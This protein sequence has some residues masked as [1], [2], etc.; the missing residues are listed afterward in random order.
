M[1]RL[2]RMR[3]GMAAAVCAAMALVPSVA[4]ASPSAQLVYVRDAT[5]V[6]CPDETALRA[7]VKRRVGYDPFFPWAKTT[8]IVEVGGTG[9]EYV[10]HVRLVDQTGVSRGDRELRSGPKGCSGLVD[11]AA[12]A[13]SIALDMNALAEPV[14]SPEP[15]PEAT[16]APAD[17]PA[18]PPAPAPLAPAPAPEADA[19][20]RP[21]PVA[22]QGLVGL[23]GV[24][25]IGTSPA[26]PSLLPGLDL[27]GAVRRGRGSL[28]LDVRADWPSTT[29]QGEARAAVVLVASSLAPCLHLGPAFGCAVGSLGWI[30]V[31]GERVE[32][33]FF[34]SFG[35]RL[36]VEVPFGRL[37]SFRLRGDL[38]VNPLGPAIELG[39]SSPR[40]TMSVVSGLVA[41]GLAYRFP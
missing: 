28:A 26:S 23:D 24:A 25:A 38:L 5:S 12:L 16:P 35:P 32:S 18:P 11:A 30:H 36:G 40:W 31:A 21:P 13:I 15:A 41:A 29:R 20:P 3:H 22:L 34:P 6:A 27:W 33:R 10:A 2:S 17:D 39:T 7:A 19:V 9:K 1:S 37:L 14:P 4:E 8:M